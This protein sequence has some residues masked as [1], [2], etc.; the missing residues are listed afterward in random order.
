MKHSA[1]ALNGDCSSVKAHY[2]KLN[3]KYNPF[4]YE[5]FESMIIN[6]HALFMHI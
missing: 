1:Q 6:I 2:I 5:D 3:Q 4:V